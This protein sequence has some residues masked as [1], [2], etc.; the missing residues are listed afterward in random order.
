MDDN[1][2]NMMEDMPILL[3][4]GSFFDHDFG[5]YRVE[6]YDKI[7]DGSKVVMCERQS[8]VALNFIENF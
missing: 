6:S 1:G 8:V 5:T 4:I 2:S 3:P 7:E